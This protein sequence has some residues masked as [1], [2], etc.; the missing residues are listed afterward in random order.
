MCV[1]LVVSRYQHVKHMK[2]VHALS[3]RLAIGAISHRIHVNRSLAL[4]TELVTPI[5]QKIFI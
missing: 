2:L 4:G 1:F 3:D 5:F